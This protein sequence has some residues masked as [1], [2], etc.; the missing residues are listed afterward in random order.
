MFEKGLSEP[1][2]HHLLGLQ[3][4]KS[5]RER[6]TQGSVVEGLRIAI[7]L[8]IG[9]WGSRF[10]I[11]GSD[12]QA[13]LGTLSLLH[14]A[15]V[16]WSTLLIR[17]GIRHNGTSWSS[18]LN[19]KFPPSLPLR[20][21]LR[22]SS[23]QCPNP[24]KEPIRSLDLNPKPQLLVTPRTPAS[25]IRDSY[26]SPTSHPFRVYGSCNHRSTAFA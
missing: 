24:K 2:K 21:D 13:W 26:G 3:G 22:P 10:C 9:I 16:V 7:R 8:G 6:L 23:Y 4:R 25:L 11:L 15:P 5:P 19:P 12:F 20:R 14:H 18:P 1:G 17:V